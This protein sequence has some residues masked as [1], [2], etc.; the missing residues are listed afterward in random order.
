MAG[1][2]HRASCNVHSTTGTRKSLRA[3]ADHQNV[4]YSRPLAPPVQQST[5][6]GVGFYLDKIPINP[7]CANTFTSIRF[8]LLH[9]R[10]KGLCEGDFS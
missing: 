7:I 2:S 3:S 6:L 9:S 1:A 4:F 8:N 10:L 5:A